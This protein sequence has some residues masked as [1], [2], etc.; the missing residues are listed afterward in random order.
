V[1]LIATTPPSLFSASLV[2]K[3]RTIATDEF[4][5]WS[6]GLRFKPRLF[7]GPQ[8]EDALRICILEARERGGAVR[9]A[10]SGHSSS[11]LVRN[12]DVVVS[13]EHFRGLI[14][15]DGM[16][17]QALVGAGTPLHELG[18]LLHDAGLAMENL[19]DVDT[20][21]IAGVVST[22]T[23]GS[24]RKLQNIS[25]K[26]I[27]ARLVTGEGEICDWRFE[28]VPERVRA[29]RVS[30]G[31][32]G[33]LTAL[34][35]QLEPAY[36]LR[37]R[38]YCAHVDDCLANL[39]AIADFHR[40]FDFYWYPRRDDVKIRTLNPPE[41]P[42]MDMPFAQ[43]VYEEEGYSHEIIARTR[44]LKFEEIEYFTPADAGPAC[45]RAVRRRILE[46]HRKHVGWRVLFRL[47][48]ADDAWL[49]P[50]HGRDSVAISIHQNAT[51]PY[52]TYFDDLEPVL[53]DHGGRPHWGK[54][55]SLHGAEL[56]AL[57]PEW[58]RFHTLRRELDPRG[59]LLSPDLALLFGEDAA[60]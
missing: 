17:H 41:L 30:L 9:A 55:H 37:R 44:E 18:G 3:F 51:L 25:A 32:L 38:E 27:G 8:N 26:L 2:S 21:T 31:S 46:R 1:Q 35:L 43:C 59:V 12:S 14:E 57:Y 60:A 29:L 48:A 24:G 15:H 7:I 40:N 39:D 33:V 19:G 54:R 4:V 16:R 22:G 53:R 50:V 56:A 11:P 49:S 13:L 6:G 28:D 20:Q 47:V 5:N 52:Q 10:G 34:R 58:K 23:H 36:R 45:F 42:V